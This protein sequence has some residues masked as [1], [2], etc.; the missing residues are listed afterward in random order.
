MEFIETAINAALHAGNEILKIYNSEDFEINT[1]TDKSPVTAADINSNNKIIEFLLDTEIPFV[2]EESNILEYDKRK[3]QNIFWLIDPL[4]GTKEFINRNGEF[5]V[6]IA[7][8]EN[9]KP[10]AGVIYA[11]VLKELYFS[12]LSVGAFKIEN[13]FVVKN[14]IFSLDDLLTLAAK[15][16]SKEKREN[17]IV[18]SSKSH[19][20]PENEAYI[21]K[22]SEKHPD[23]KTISKGSSLK[24]CILAEGKADIYPRFGLTSE[25]DTAAGHAILKAAGGNVFN[26]KTHDEIYYNKENILNPYFIAVRNISEIKIV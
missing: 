20:T 13:I 19:I 11:P 2:S 23:I 14:Q 18:I 17:L 5:T 4:D 3:N 26:A 6:N 15:L 24:I 22:L 8:I 1:K 9:G 25:W 10:V 16:P 7:L 12:H 21:K